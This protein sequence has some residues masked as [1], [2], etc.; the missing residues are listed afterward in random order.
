MISE[1][2]A[3][4]PSPVV[5]QPLPTRSTSRNV[6]TLAEHT[7][8]YCTKRKERR[9][10][11]IQD[12]RENT[13][14]H[15]MGMNLPSFNGTMASNFETIRFPLKCDF[16]WLFATF[17]QLWNLEILWSQHF[18]VIC[19]AGH[20]SSANTIGILFQKYVSSSFSMKI[21]L[22]CIHIWSVDLFLV[23]D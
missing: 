15:F 8:S 4:A 19:A 6:D 13:Y 5:Q 3:F 9:V 20:R 10:R 17:K 23:E 21:T 11:K 12:K 14:P 7:H 16:S 18:L 2:G 22:N 1:L